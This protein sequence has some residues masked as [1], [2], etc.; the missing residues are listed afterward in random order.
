MKPESLT[1]VPQRLKKARKVS[2]SYVFHALLEQGWVLIITCLVFLIPALVYYFLVPAVFNSGVSFQPESNKSAPTTGRSLL[3]QLESPTLIRTTLDQFSQTQRLAEAT[4]YKGSAVDTQT[5]SEHIA[6]RMESLINDN[7]GKISLTMRTTDP[8]VTEEFLRELIKNFA[9]S[10]SVVRS[11]TA[12]ESLKSIEQSLEEAQK[13]S[14]QAEARLKEFN[15]Q[16]Q[17][18]N[19]DGSGN[20]ISKIDLLRKQLLS[21]TEE[22]TQA[23][24]DYDKVEKLR[25][26]SAAL[27]D[28]PEISSHSAVQ[29]IKLQFSEQQNLINQYLLSGMTEDKPELITARARLI[30]INKVMVDVVLQFPDLLQNEFSKAELLLRQLEEN[31]QKQ[32]QINLELT[33]DGATGQSL[34]QDADAARIRYEGLLRAQS[35]S[36]GVKEASQLKPLSFEPISLPRVPVGLNPLLIL[37]IITAVGFVL[38]LIL[39]FARHDRNQRVRTVHEAEQSLEVPVI[40][41]VP[42]DS[43]IHQLTPEALQKRHKDEPLMEAYRSLRAFVSVATQGQNKRLY[44][45]TSPNQGDGK[46]S[47]AIHFALAQAQSGKKTLLVDADLRRP[48]LSRALFKDDKLAGLTDYALGLNSLENLSQQLI[49]NLYVLPS[50]R[51]VPNPSELLTNPW[52]KE[53]MEQA[54]KHYDFVVL[55]SAPINTVADTV[56]LLPYVEAVCLVIN[57]KENSVQSLVQAI[58]SIRRGQANLLGLILNRM[59]KDSVVAY[60]DKPTDKN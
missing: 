33:T 12:L 28:L 19:P 54:G 40:G 4:S 41:V 58:Q 17:V 51:R 44:L 38:G 50:G 47:S 26:N 20:K 39:T 36:L 56:L 13:V 42:L 10:T 16:V 21:V 30:E 7:S 8:A 18:L 15:E 57:I 52:L 32:E 31:I 60:G 49:P 9:A 35:E 27:L 46:T 45:I 23:K 3:P 37:I 34:K 11:N 2:P 59:P 29:E 5:L 55:D 25:G 53:F 1:D 43:S 22:A 6:V 24:L 48:S 14:L